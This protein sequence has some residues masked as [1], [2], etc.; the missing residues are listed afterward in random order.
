MGVHQDK[1]EKTATLYHNHHYHKALVQVQSSSPSDSSSSA[2]SSQVSHWFTCRG[3]F[4]NKGSTQMAAHVGR[5]PRS[6]AWLFT[7]SSLPS[8]LKQGFS[9]SW[10]FV[11]NVFLPCQERFLFD[12]LHIIQVDKVAQQH[13]CKQF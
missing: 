9:F 11:G 2:V 4:K 6:R 1:G 7:N 8:Y 3:R 13:A 10:V 5:L 12:D